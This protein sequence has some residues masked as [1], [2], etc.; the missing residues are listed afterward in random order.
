MSR[1]NRQPSPLRHALLGSR[2]PAGYA[3]SAHDLM[4]VPAAHARYVHAMR[5]PRM[6]PCALPQLMRVT[7]MSLSVRDGGGACWAARVRRRHGGSARPRR[8]PS[9]RLTSSS[10]VPPPSAPQRSWGPSGGTH[11]SPR[12]LC[13]RCG[14]RSRRRG[15]RGAG[16]RGTRAVPGACLLC[17]VGSEPA[18]PPC[19]PPPRTFHPVSG[20]HSRRRAHLPVFLTMRKNARMPMPC[21]RVFPRG[22]CV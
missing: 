15:S 5:V 22:V 7:R 16:E 9:A 3:R 11:P 18:A 8:R 14:S 19:P 12:S 2:R 1:G 6:A 13:A 4:R 20:S 21:T 10:S 17:E